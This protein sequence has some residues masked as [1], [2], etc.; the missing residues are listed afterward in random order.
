MKAISKCV[1]VILAIFPALAFASFETLSF[2]C[3]S[4]LVVSQ[5]NGYQASCDGDFSLESGTLRN[6]ISIKLTSV[7][8]LNINMG[9]SLIAPFIELA[10]PTIKLASGAVLDAGYIGLPINSSEIKVPYIIE[11]KTHLVVSQVPEPSNWSMLAMG[12]FAVVVV[13][14]R[15]TK[16]R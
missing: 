7:G 8:A 6:E 5:D 16:N 3:S 14:S 9:V 2:S 12:L 10:S 1:F 4:N 13:V 11:P 15:K